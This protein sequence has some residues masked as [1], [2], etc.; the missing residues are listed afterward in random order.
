MIEVEAFVAIVRAGSF[1]GAAHELYLSQPAISR[2]IDLLETEI[3]VRLFDRI[4]GGVRLTEAG[5]AFLPY[6]RQVL[7]AARD[8]T[9]AARALEREPAGPIALALVGTLA[10]TRLTERLRLFRER[11]PAVRLLLKTARSDE[12]TAMVQ[13]GEA[14]LGLRYFAGSQQGL[15][16][17]PVAKEPLRV[18]RAAQSRLVSSIDGVETLAGVPWIG[19]S[20]STSS[21]GEPFALAVERKLTEAGLGDVERITIDSL[22]AQKRLIEADFGIGLLPASSVEEELRLGTLRAL[23]VAAL[24]MSIP[25]VAIHRRDGYLSAAARELLASLVEGGDG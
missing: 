16:A 12:V 14:R 7:A 11:W 17:L 13:R 25:V 19:F 2:R 9:E 5:E 8:G 24:A 20:S 1:S 4:P 6:A 22:T 23:P 18:V 3:G 10:S 15:V 21:S